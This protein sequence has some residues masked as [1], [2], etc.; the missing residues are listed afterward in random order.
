MLGNRLRQSIYFRYLKILMYHL[1]VWPYGTTKMP[2]SSIKI[3]NLQT[4]EIIKSHIDWF[5]YIIKTIHMSKIDKSLPFYIFLLV[6]KSIGHNHWSNTREY[7]SCDQIWR[8][9]E[10]LWTS[11][12]HHRRVSRLSF[13]LILCFICDFP[14]PVL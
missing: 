1:K 11:E 3:H 13:G 10:F 6:R 9:V 8:K 7:W 5:E 4:I 2:V 12:I 14:C